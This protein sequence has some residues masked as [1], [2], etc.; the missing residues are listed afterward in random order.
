M[1]VTHKTLMEM[2]RII[3]GKPNSTT[4][5]TVEGESGIGKTAFAHQL[6]KALPEYEDQA[7]ILPVAQLNMEDLGLPQ[8]S[9]DKPFTDFK[10]SELFHT[11][12]KHVLMV[13]DELNRPSNDTV[14]NSVM[15]VVNERR[16]FGQP[17]SDKI[18]FIATL[19]PN[20]SAYADTQPIFDDLA[21][22]RR[23]NIVELKFDHDEFIKYVE[24]KKFD[25]TLISFIKQ[26]P[27]NVVTRDSINCPRQWER[28][29][30]DV[31][32]VREWKVEDKTLMTYMAS[33]YM[34][35]P[36]LSLWTKHW[37]GE[38][39]KF[40]PAKDIV[41]HYGKVRKNILKY[42]KE[43]RMDVL[44]ASADDVR[45]YMI[46]LAEPKAKEI[47]NFAKFMLDLPVAMAFVVLEEV[48]DKAVSAT[49]INTR[50]AKNK[51]I[52]ELIERGC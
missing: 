5:L 14:F 4:I 52:M 23:F 10:I 39:E 33:L 27:D 30:N 32:K 12:D 28:F 24:G 9:D 49:E 31:L 40:I 43:E 18:H 46:E 8:N 37:Q 48:V 17:I 11:T 19:N 20:N 7:R 41:T 26:F 50:L 51:E 16:L 42:V 3:Y 15:S 34:D 38:L 45:M 36:T 1:K 35:T 13:L 47:D 22:L 2:G 6:A 29:N 21:G 44:Q 25:P